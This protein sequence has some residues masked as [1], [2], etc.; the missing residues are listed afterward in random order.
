LLAKGR[1]N[2]ARQENAQQE[3]SRRV[4]RLSMKEDF[5]LRATKTGYNL[6][7]NPDPDKL[8]KTKYPTA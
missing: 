4:T 7:P 3:K 2:L 1:A 5:F 6:G 8:L